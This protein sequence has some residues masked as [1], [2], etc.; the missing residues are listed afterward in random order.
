LAND[1]LSVGLANV[2]PGTTHCTGSRLPAVT[3]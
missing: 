2:A 1:I 3:R